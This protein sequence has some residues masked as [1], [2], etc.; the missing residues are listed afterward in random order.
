[1]PIDRL[2]ISSLLKEQIKNYETK[3]QTEEVGTVI[4]VG[5]GIALV[6]GLDKAM[7]GELLVFPNDVFGMVQNL[8]KNHVGVILLNDSSSI[9]EGDEVKTTGTILEV[10]VGPELIGR[11]VNPLGQPLDGLGKINT[12]KTRPIEK[13]AT[14]VI[15]RQSVN[16]PLQTGIKVLDALVPIGRGQRELIIGDRQTGKS[17]LAIDTIIN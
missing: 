5:D 1:M 7:S 4:S 2:E 10:P 6:Y 17:A 8:E 16:Q 11:V 13:K 12:T 15:E 3:V 9:K 14:G